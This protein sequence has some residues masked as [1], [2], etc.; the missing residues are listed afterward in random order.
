MDGP[1]DL[2]T[3]PNESRPQ[4]K[5]RLAENNYVT[6]LF[7]RLNLIIGFDLENLYAKRDISSI[8][9]GQRDRKRES[10]EFSNNIST[11][12]KKQHLV[13]AMEPFDAQQ[14][15]HNPVWK[16]CFATQDSNIFPISRGNGCQLE[17][18][19]EL[20]LFS[21]GDLARKVIFG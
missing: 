4:I 5:D 7:Q 14:A 15:P 17:M 18:S 3:L 1:R 10:R 12:L 9:E 2:K 13:T 11:R 8:D 20:F 16:K 6:V 19:S 21:A